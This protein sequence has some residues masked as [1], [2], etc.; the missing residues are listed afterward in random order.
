[1]REVGI[2]WG[3]ARPERILFTAKETV[4]VGEYLVGETE[5]G[6]V[7]YMV[8]GFQ[9][10]STLLLK[11]MDYITAEEARRASEVNPRDRMRIGVARA[12]GLIE[13]LKRGRRIYPTVPPEP[14][15]SVALADDGILS[16]VYCQKGERWAEVGCLLR[17]RSIRVSVDLNA[18]ASRHL[19]ILAATG[20]GKS[21][22]LALLAKRVAERNGTMVIVDYH[23]EYVGLSIPRLKV[24]VPKLN[25][26]RLSVEEL[27]DVIGVRE[28]AERQ[29]A[30]LGEV[31]DENVK[32]ENVR[33]AE[34]FWKV[35]KN[36]LERIAKDEN[37]TAQERYTAKRLVEIIERALRIWGPIFDQHARSLIDQIYPNRVNVLDVSG[38]TEA[39]AQVLVSYLLEELLENRKDAVKGSEARFDSPVIVAIEEAH[40][41]V[42][43]GRRTYCSEIIAKVAREGRKFGLS[44]ILVSQ[45]PSRLNSDV[46]SQMGSFAISGLTHPADQRFI[47]E[48]T[49]EVTDELGASL[50]SLNPGE[51][52][53]VGSF[54]RAPVLIKADYV[55]EKMVGRDIDAVSEWKRA[56]G[57]R[58]P[59]TTEELIKL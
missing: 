33:R 54:V 15:D 43:S 31:L 28:G 49:D 18:I 42:P 51:M 46:I 36:K 30:M 11:A 16:E 10:V 58:P 40:V 29:R 47:M 26:T 37:R 5:D 56:A 23:S 35:L 6:P 45:R 24:T 41:F 27:A 44:L 39:Q 25:P 20:K 32:D 17:R 19:A 21:N 9:S 3:A 57:E 8:D 2:I 12:I 13:E 50:P 38:F 55:G 52:I 53:L 22:F 34:D 7:L 1:L 48:V 4:R 59:Y 14:G